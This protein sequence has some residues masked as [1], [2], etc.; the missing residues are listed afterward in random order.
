MVGA[1]DSSWGVSVEQRRRVLRVSP[2]P[3]RTGPCALSTVAG[4]LARVGSTGRCSFALER[5]LDSAQTSALPTA[6]MPIGQE[7]W[8]HASSSRRVTGWTHRYPLTPSTNRVV[9]WVVFGYSDY[10]IMLTPCANIF[11]RDRPPFRLSGP[12][13]QCVAEYTN[14]SHMDQSYID[15]PNIWVPTGACRCP[16]GR[17]EFNGSSPCQDWRCIRSQYKR[18]SKTFDLSTFSGILDAWLTAAQLIRSDQLPQ[19]TISTTFSNMLN[20]S[21]PLSELE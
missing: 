2:R 18:L 4:G 9:D 6:S 15:V 8:A 12:P 1:S 5:G 10:R 3:Q 16:Y 11:E 19:R 14:I 21:K 20:P 17:H 13:T 7:S